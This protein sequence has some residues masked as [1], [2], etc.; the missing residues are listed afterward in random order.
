MDDKKYGMTENCG[1]LIRMLIYNHQ[2]NRPV[3]KS[4]I[5]KFLTIDSNMRS[6]ILKVAQNYLNK[7]NLKM[8]GV[9]GSGMVCYKDSDKIFL[10]KILDKKS[11]KT[12]VTLNDD[13][14]V[15]F[16]LIAVIK[17][18]NNKLEERKTKLLDECKLFKSMSAEEYLKI[19]KGQGYFAIEKIEE[20][21]NWVFGW[22]YYVEFDDSDN[23]IEY[24]CNK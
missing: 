24:F 16:F 12:K 23:I 19:F 10:R 5:N 9:S 11:K 20:K 2:K 22:R 4:E 21:E 7:F 17:L 6:S 13:E 1:K 14:K 18:E 8:V 15:L 3:F